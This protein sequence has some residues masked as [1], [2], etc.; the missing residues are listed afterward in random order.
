MDLRQTA[1]AALIALA[2][3]DAVIPVPFAALFMLYIVLVR[4]MWLPTVLGRI[5]R[6]G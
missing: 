6:S 5:Y 3:I 1:I 2:V 4:P